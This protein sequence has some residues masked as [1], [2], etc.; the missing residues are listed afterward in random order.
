M[1]AILMEYGGR[2]QAASVGG[3]WRRQ[4]DLE[5]SQAEMK[6]LDGLNLGL[7]A[8]RKLVRVCVCAHLYVL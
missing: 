6:A 7:R 3:V 4:V 5:H 1:V 8:A 2:S